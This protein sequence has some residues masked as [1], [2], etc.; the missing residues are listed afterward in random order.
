[1]DDPLQLP[2]LDDEENDEKVAHR[3]KHTCGEG[4]YEQGALEPRV[5]GDMVVVVCWTV[6]EW[7]HLFRFQKVAEFCYLNWN[8]MDTSVFLEN[9]RR[10]EICFTAIRLSWDALM[11]LIGTKIVL[12]MGRSSKSLPPFLNKILMCPLMF[13]RL[14]IYSQGSVSTLSTRR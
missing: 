8:R 14:Y 1:M 6:I 7:R 10:L 13:M 2:T 12:N 9:K 3:P 11:L 5:H 4:H